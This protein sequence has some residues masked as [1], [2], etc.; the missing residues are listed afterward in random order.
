[1]EA[2][3]SLR[4]LFAELSRPGAADPAE[5]LRAAGFG[6]VPGSLVA[7]AIVSY[8]GTAPLEVAEH[9]APFAVAHGP[10]P[11]PDPAFDTAPPDGLTL[12]ASAPV[13][14][15]P[16]DDPP[17]DPPVDPTA[18]LLPEPPDPAPEHGGAGHL[19]GHLD[20]DLDGHLH[21]EV[22]LDPSALDDPSGHPAP[23]PVHPV[24]ADPGP[25]DVDPAGVDGLDRIGGPAPGAG[26][27]PQI[28]D[29]GAGVGA[30]GPAPVAAGHDDPGTVDAD[31]DRHV[32]P[33][34]VHDHDQEVDP[35]GAGVTDH[36]LS[37]TAAD[38]PPPLD[39]GAGTDPADPPDGEEHHHL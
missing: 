11:T 17:V 4:E 25:T 31:A 33:L 22:D 34:P 9:L 29:F 28:A 26:G 8:A 18:A 24:H 39:H 16:D 23:H 1:M 30:G 2:G 32:D 13:D 3:R 35:D 15:L 14:D 5:L 21:G 38:G 7:E 12:L 37:V 19:E 27:H 10:L 36:H 20:G 6:D